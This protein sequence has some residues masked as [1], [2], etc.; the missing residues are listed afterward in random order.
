[1]ADDWYARFYSAVFPI[2]KV[3]AVAVGLATRRPRA[4]LPRLLNG[5]EHGWGKRK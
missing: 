3:A 2:G 4:N 1:M 5:T